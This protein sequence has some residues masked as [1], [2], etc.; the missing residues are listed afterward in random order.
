MTVFHTHYR[1]SAGRALLIGTTLLALTACSA[2]H[3]EQGP[4]HET[5]AAPQAAAAPAPQAGVSVNMPAMAAAPVMAQ[6]PVN[7]ER[8]EDVDPNPVKIAA[9]DPVSTFSIDVDTA[10]YSNVRR[11]LNEGRCRRATRCA[12]KS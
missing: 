8:Y 11:F 9:E 12:S 3:A 6:P 5:N 10:S 2:Q 7:T 1:R 4:S